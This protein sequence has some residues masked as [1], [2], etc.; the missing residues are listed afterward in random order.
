MISKYN[1]SNAVRD[2]QNSDIIID[3]SRLSAEFEDFQTGSDN[4]NSPPMI[5]IYTDAGI[6][7]DN[8]SLRKHSQ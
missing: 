2:Y 8:T 3:K 6:E 5:N 1:P 7:M 4:K